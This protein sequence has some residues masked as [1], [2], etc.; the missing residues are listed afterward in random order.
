MSSKSK[1]K[2]PRAAI[3]I[4]V[5]YQ[6]SGKLVSEFTRDVSRGGLFIKTDNPLEVGHRCRLALTFPNRS[7]PVSVGGVVRRIISATGEGQPGM[8]IGFLFSDEDEQMML[9]RTVDHSMIEQLGSELYERLSDVTT[10][11]TVTGMSAYDSSISRSMES[12]DVEP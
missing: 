5:D 6:H 3:E 12:I 4:R 10:K 1:R 11:D 7:E 2:A 9:F 8:G